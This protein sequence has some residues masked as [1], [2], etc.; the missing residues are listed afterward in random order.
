MGMGM[1]MGMG[2]DSNAAVRPAHIR[3]TNSNPSCSPTLQDNLLS[4]NLRGR[5]V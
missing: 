4:T 2:M 5:A 1:G 3:S